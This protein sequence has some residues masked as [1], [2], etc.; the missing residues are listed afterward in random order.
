MRKRTYSSYNN[1]NEYG[2]E[3]KRRRKNPEDIQSIPY[4]LE[5]IMATPELLRNII[6]QL[7][8]KDA[9]RYYNE[10]MKTNT[11]NDEQFID[12]FKD[13]FSHII[14]GGYPDTIDIPHN[15]RFQTMEDFCD[16]L[17]YNEFLGELTVEF[18]GVS[19]DMPRCVRLNQFSNRINLHVYIP[20]GETTI[21][22]YAFIN[23]SSLT[24]VTFPNT[25]TTIREYAF[26]DCSRLTSVTFPNTLTTIGRRA[27]YRCSSLTSVT[28]PNTLTTIGHYAF[29]WCSSLKDMTLPDSLSNIGRGAFSSCSSLIDVTFPNTLTTIREGAFSG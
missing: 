23:C 7:P 4:N 10:I 15:C 18:Y 6:N 19:I 14:V 22:S 21:G 20:E 27:F 28:F 16:T 8:Y 24:S 12:I 2:G 3:T 26:A 5:S 1:E 9:M 17:E 25:L 29:S 13:C 11:E